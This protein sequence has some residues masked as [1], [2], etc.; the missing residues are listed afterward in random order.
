MI[1]VTVLGA[2]GSIGASTLDVLRRHMDR[3]QLI[4][5]TAHSDVERMRVLCMEWQP[6]FAVMSDPDAAGRLQGALMQTAP[7][8]TI[9]SGPEGLIHVAGL[10]EGDVVA[11]AGVFWLCTY[12]RVNIMARVGQ[13]LIFDLRA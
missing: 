13:S 12:L 1:G 10:N 9:L 5:V 2:T 4:A 7:D 6:R 11:G 8:V 3:Y